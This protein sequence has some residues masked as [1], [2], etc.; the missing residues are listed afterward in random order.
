MNVF[1]QYADGSTLNPVYAPDHK[2][3]VI[4][5]YKELIGSRKLVGRITITMDN[6]EVINL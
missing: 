1:I 2:A 3:S 4:R 5:Y 6:G